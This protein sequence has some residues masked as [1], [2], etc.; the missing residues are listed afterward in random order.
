MA[1][2]VQR[3]WT[4]GSGGRAAQRAAADLHG[5]GGRHDHRDQP[6]RSGGSRPAV[7]KLDARSPDRLS[8]R[9]A[10]T[11]DQPQPDRRALAAGRVTLAQARNVV[12]RAAG[13]RL[14]RKK[15][16]I[17]ALYEQP[18]AGSVVICLDEMGPERAKSYLGVRVAARDAEVTRR[19][20]ARQEI[21]YGRPGSGYT[22]GAFRP[23]TGDAFTAPYGGRSIAN[24]CAFLEQVDDWVGRDA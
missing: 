6:D 7:R 22:F 20:R 23:A 8:P 5:R 17:V 11:H 12:W 1:E 13:P 14:R 16:A 21:D 24:W 15:G 9:S 3:G 2:A 18:P 4:R 10:G 19:P